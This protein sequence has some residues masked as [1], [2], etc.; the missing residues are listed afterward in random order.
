MTANIPATGKPEA[1]SGVH[2]TAP[3]E[4][5]RSRS[6]DPGQSS[7]GGFKNENPGKQKQQLDSD[8]AGHE[9]ESGAGDDGDGGGDG[10]D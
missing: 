9:G 3:G 1:T 4:E 8:S 7:Y 2:E 5:I 10:G 6:A